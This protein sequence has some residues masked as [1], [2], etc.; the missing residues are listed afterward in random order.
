MSKKALY[1]LGIVLTILIGMW[2]QHYFCCSQGCCD[3]NS[4]SSSSEIQNEP[5]PTTPEV[6]L[7]GFEFGTDSGKLFSTSEN[8]R[9][10]NSKADILLPVSDSIDLGIEKLKSV[11]NNSDTK[12]NILGN[13]NPEEPNNSIFPDLGLAR[14]TA[15]KNYL[16]SKGVDEKRL[17]VASIQNATIKNTDTIFSATQMALW[18]DVPQTNENQTTDWEKQKAE[19]NANPIR[20]Y[21]ET[22]KSEINL[23]QE[24]KVQIFKIME[25]VNAVEG[26]KIAV[27]GHTDNIVGVNA[28]NAVYSKRRADFVK[29]YLISNGINSDKI[30]TEGKAETQPIAD[31][32]TAEGRAKNRRVEIILE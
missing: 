27:F 9:F 26:S 15:V 22:G 3:A 28:T 12:Y 16:V 8:F 4:D 14:A 31:N 20:L 18:I 7:H 6:K 17:M 1:L 32:T 11:L 25:Y 13:Y 30:V 19:I 2:L 29:E 5:Q 21:F 23:S 24:Q 10:L